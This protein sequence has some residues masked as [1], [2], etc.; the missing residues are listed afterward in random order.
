M[1][2]GLLTPDVLLKLQEVRN[3]CIIAHVDHGKTTL[4][5]SLIS[6]NGIISERSAGQLRFMDSLAEEQERQ[7]TLKSSSISL[8]YLKPSRVEGQKK[9][10]FLINLIDSPG[11]VDFGGEVSVAVRLSDGA[12]VVVDAVEGVCVQTH[13]TLK[14]ALREGVK[15]VLFINKFDRLVVE[16][17]CT[18]EEAYESIGKLI[19]QMNGLMGSILREL[20]QSK[21]DSSYSE[22]AAHSTVLDAAFE[23]GKPLVLKFED[24]S[25]DDSGIRYFEPAEGNVVFGSAVDGWAFSLDDFANFY[26]PKLK[27]EVDAVKKGLWGPYFFDTKEVTFKPIPKDSKKKL[28]AFATLVL[29]QVWAA[30]ECTLVES[31]D[32]KLGKIVSVLGLKV[33]SRDLHSPDL[34]HRLRA[35]MQAWLPLAP[36]VLRAVVETVPSPA[37]GQA[38]KL[39][40]LWPSLM[41]ISDK[42][43][44]SVNDLSRR[45][46]ITQADPEGP[47]LFGACKLLRVD[48]DDGLS[49]IPS[50]EAVAKKANAANA[51][52]RQ[53]VIQRIKAE[54]A[55][56]SS[57]E[58][59]EPKTTEVQG[60]DGNAAGSESPDRDGDVGGEEAKTMEDAD[61]VLTEPFLSFGRLWSGRIRDGQSVLVVTES[62]K[63]VLKFIRGIY[64]LM[65]RYVKRVPEVRAG[66]LCCLS[67]LEECLNFREMTLVDPETAPILMPPL[68][69]GSQSIVRIAV[70]PDNA[71]DFAKMQAGLQLLARADPA[72]RVELQDNGE[73]IISGTGELHLEHCLKTLREQYAACSVTASAPRVPFRETVISGGKTLSVIMG[74]EMLSLRC[75][76]LKKGTL[77]PVSAHERLSTLDIVAQSHGNVLFWKDASTSAASSEVQNAIRAGWLLASNSGPLCE[78][79]ML[80]V[81]TVLA[82]TPRP[83]SD[84]EEE[85]TSHVGRWITAVNQLC[86][87]AFQT[88]SRR[89][90]EPFYHATLLCAME[91]L[92]G[93]YAVLSKRRGKILNEEMLDGTTLFRVE[94]DLPVLESFGFTTD[95]RNMTS[96]LAQPQL[97]LGGWQMIETDPFWTATT[98]EELEEYGTD[99]AGAVNLARRLIQDVRRRKGLWV[100]TKLVDA[101]EKQRTLKR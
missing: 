100:E 33:P 3:I 81:G 61:E 63:P 80:G 19:E 87:E 77:Q 30:Y 22:E 29:K 47:L 92:S 6:S 57:G 23:S 14:Q 69:V 41:T 16:K 88:C 40:A 24:S 68:S 36:C 5:D 74:S 72:V 76:P 38:A 52:L 78:E 27:V 84:E 93:L 48:G 65:G 31:D 34:K 37:E 99:S 58:E 90:V 18:P 86:R 97:V 20:K 8:V 53:R 54:Q 42:G 46:R 50:E 55:S 9:D 49:L 1:S 67:G 26:A 73:W 91:A 83:T 43:E 17:Q 45:Q 79:P 96:G 15:P 85:G 94:A 95:L 62:G 44:A 28:P 75:I 32:T 51:A 101:A 12:I 11:H 39:E 21:D 13:T 64:L 60:E 35:V 10:P 4:A 2:F 89:L 98:E 82:V 56:T 25:L 71:A 70:E 59:G 66:H 7:I